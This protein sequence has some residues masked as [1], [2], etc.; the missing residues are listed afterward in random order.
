MHK[1]A[2]RDAFTLIELLVVIAI[3]AILAGLLLPALAKAKAKAISIQCM[4]NNKQLGIAWIMYAGDNT[5]SLAA[6]N[7]K[8]PL[9]GYNKAI[10]WICPFGVSLD[11]SSSFNNNFDTSYLTANNAILGY[12]LMGP[13]VASSLKIFVCP[14]DRF[15][16]PAQRSTTNQNRIR[17][18][19]MDGAMGYGS[20]Y[21]AGLWPQFYNVKKS[22]DMH[23]PGPSGCWVITDEHP[24]SDDDASF[25]VNP[26]D[27]N[28][29]GSD[30]MWTEL[31]G[32]M[33]AQS[34]GMVFGDGHSEIHKWKGG[35][36]T[37]P[38]AY[39]TYLQSVSVS[40]DQ[41]SQQDL[42]WLAQRTPQN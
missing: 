32:S 5:D 39:K 35:L 12:A 8:D 17:S 33:H 22:G 4:N 26:A 41:A 11:W 37:Q 42:Q 29:V 40:T 18:V 6:N 20:K 1:S 36:T 9:P 34:A 25:F 13:Y 15:L 19:A 38:V 16:S 31:P 2:R 27:A 30:N 10:N 3:I 24:D 23:T 7:D 14:A 21:F 28:V